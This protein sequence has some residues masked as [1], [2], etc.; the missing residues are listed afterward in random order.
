MAPLLVLVGQAIGQPM[1]LDF[2]PFGSG[3]SDRSCQLISLDGRSNWLEG[4][5]LLAT[6]VVLGAAFYSSS[7]I[8]NP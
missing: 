2:N 1:D 5:L 7:L 6:Y 4:T 8:D 3:C